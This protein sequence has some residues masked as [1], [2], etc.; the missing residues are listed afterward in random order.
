MK[1]IKDLAG[2]KYGLWRVITLDADKRPAR[3]WCECTGCGETISVLASSLKQG[4][5]KGC[6]R[7][8]QHRPFQEAPKKDLRGHRFGFLVAREP[9]YCKRR[10]YWRCEC[11]C[12]KE[13]F[14]ASGTDLEMNK[15]TSCGCK[16]RKKGELNGR[17]KGVGDLSG[18]IWYIILTNAKSRKLDVLLTKQEA[19]AQFQEQEGRCALSGLPID[20]G[21]DRT[22]SLDRIDSTKGYETGN[23]QWVH[24]AINQMKWDLSEDK[25]I[26]YCCLIVEHSKKRSI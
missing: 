22:A 24:K 3:W 17:W 21:K 13:D 1:N 15:V 8:R 6:I 11:D 12:G 7:C 26:E 19:W 9:A 10:W 18:S 25:F 14:V 5:S 16:K 4:K 20:L 2:Q 23:V